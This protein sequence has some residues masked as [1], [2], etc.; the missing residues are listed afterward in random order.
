MSNSASQNV[1]DGLTPADRLR[2][3]LKERKISD[4]TSDARNKIHRSTI[5][6]ILGEKADYIPTS[7]VRRRLANILNYDIYRPDDADEILLSKL[8]I[9]KIKCMC[10]SA[11][12]SFEIFLSRH[13]KKVHGSY[14]Q[15]HDKNFSVRMLL[16]LDCLSKHRK[17]LRST[18]SELYISVLKE[19]KNGPCSVT[20]LAEHLDIHPST[21]SRTIN[22]KSNIH[23]IDANIALELHLINMNLSKFGYYGSYDLFKNYYLG[24]LEHE[25]LV[26]AL[27]QEDEVK[28]LMDEQI[29]TSS[30][31][32]MLDEDR[33]EILDPDISVEFDDT[34]W[35]T[36][37][38]SE[39]MYLN[40]TVSYTYT[41]KTGYPYFKEEEIQSGKFKIRS[42]ILGRY[43]NSELEVILE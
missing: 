29:L 14:S 42:S 26:E 13:I 40:A 43:E 27:I 7:E 22:E 8:T 35:I 39:S 6:R 16:C 11:E 31:K 37:S 36:S 12:S 4:L 32:G 17:T 2:K 34:E 33:Y 15:N 10:C 28:W 30:L 19:N 25:E 38:T 5:Y 3:I 20:D 23:L 1:N 41:I 24:K 21:I 18:Y 9:T